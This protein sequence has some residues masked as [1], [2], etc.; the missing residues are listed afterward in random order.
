MIV[1]EDVVFEVFELL[2]AEG[3]SVVSVNRLLNA[4]LTI[5]MPT[6]GNVAVI[7]WVETNCTLK[8]CLQ[9]LRTDLKVDVAALLLRN[10]WTTSVDKFPND[11]LYNLS[12]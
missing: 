9:L 8:L 5:Y 1:F 7:D 2:I 4:G 3:A 12:Y 6:P 10:H 11:L